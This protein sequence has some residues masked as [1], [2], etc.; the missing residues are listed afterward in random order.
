MAIG[1]KLLSWNRYESAKWHVGYLQEQG[2]KR[3]EDELFASVAE[4]SELFRDEWESL[5]EQLTELIEE[6][7]PRGEWYGLMENFGWQPVSGEGTFSA[8]TGKEL[9]EGILPK[10]ECVFTIYAYG[11]HGLAVNNSHHDSAVGREWYYLTPALGEAGLEIALEAATE[12]ASKLAPGVPDWTIFDSWDWDPPH[13]RLSDAY[14]DIPKAAAVIGGLA[15]CDSIDEQGID[16]EVDLSMLYEGNPW[17]D[18]AIALAM[19]Q[20]G[21]GVTSVSDKAIL[22]MA[23]DILEGVIDAATVLAVA[24]KNTLAGVIESLEKVAAEQDKE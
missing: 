17:S 13:L 2:D 21:L 8:C 14:E 11:E 6:R 4:N 3:S 12:A 7:N 5:L 1:D 22:S 20:E 18:C 24:I 16:L 15:F 19:I 10:T 9:L 23:L